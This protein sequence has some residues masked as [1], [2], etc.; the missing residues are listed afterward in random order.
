MTNSN[1]KPALAVENYFAELHRIRASGAATDERSSYGPIE[2]LLNAVGATLRPRVFC[3]GE[4]ADLGA[5]HPDMGIFNANQVQKGR[6]QK[7]QIGV[8]PV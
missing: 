2:N 6:P 4:L 7:G 3:V 5:G 8:D 1:K